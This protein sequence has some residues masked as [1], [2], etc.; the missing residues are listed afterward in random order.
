MESLGL[1]CDARSELRPTVGFK[2][3][4]PLDYNTVTSL[5]VVDEFHNESLQKQQK[6]QE[7]IS[8]TNDRT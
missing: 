6:W 3:P 4:Q 2:A 7:V 1:A 5:I 8:D